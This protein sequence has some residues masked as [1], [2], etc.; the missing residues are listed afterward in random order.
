M[1]NSPVGKW[2]HSYKDGMIH[3][4]GEVLSEPIPGR[5]VV[6]T[7]S[8]LTGA[9]WSQQTVSVADMAD[10]QLLRDRRGHDG[11]TTRAPSTERGSPGTPAA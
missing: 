3:W 8:W 10:W 9:P 7:Y 1:K 5:Y 4:Q 11:R 6:E 2:F